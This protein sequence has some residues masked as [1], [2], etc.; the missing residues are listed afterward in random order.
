VR[1]ADT[2][3][4]SVDG[5]LPVGLRAA[6]LVAA[7]RTASEDPAPGCARGQQRSLPAAEHREKYAVDS[8]GPDSGSLQLLPLSIIRHPKWTL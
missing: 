8:A 3:G 7:Q 4:A 2:P 6:A 1:G 5:E